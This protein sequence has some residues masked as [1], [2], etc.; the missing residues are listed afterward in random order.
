MIYAVINNEGNFCHYC[1]ENFIVPKNLIKI[2]L[3]ELE[4]IELEKLKVKR[5]VNSKWIEGI[6]EK[7]LQFIKQQKIDELNK[8]QYDELLVTDWY[9]NRKSDTGKEI[10]IEIINQ[11][12]E[13]R[14]KYNNLRNENFLL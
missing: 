3:S 8:I 9:G 4:L 14:L 2:E 1:D 6:T 5:Y 7:E 10:P 12:N 11:R 13:I